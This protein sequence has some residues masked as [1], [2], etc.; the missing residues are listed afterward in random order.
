MPSRESERHFPMRWK[1]IGLLIIAVILWMISPHL[2]KGQIVDEK[3]ISNCICLKETDKLVEVSMT[4]SCL[5]EEIH[6]LI[7]KG[8]RGPFRAGFYLSSENDGYFWSYEK[9]QLLWEDPLAVREKDKYVL[10]KEY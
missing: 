2:A 1:L 8:N 6:L 5:V 3:D 9:A 4:D 10:L 7:R